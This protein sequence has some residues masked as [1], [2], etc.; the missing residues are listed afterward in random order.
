MPPE[1]TAAQIEQTKPYLEPIKFDSDVTPSKRHP[2]T[3]LLFMPTNYG[4]LTGV[5]LNDKVFCQDYSIRD[6]KDKPA[7]G[8]TTITTTIN[9][10]QIEVSDYQ[11][12]RIYNFNHQ[13]NQPQIERL[14]DGNVANGVY[15]ILDKGD[16]NTIYRVKDNIDKTNNGKEHEPRIEEDELKRSEVKVTDVGRISEIKRIGEYLMVT[17]FDKQDENRTRIVFIDQ[18]GKEVL[19][20]RVGY[21]VDKIVTNQKADRENKF[22]FVTSD[23]KVVIEEL[24]DKDGTLRFG[25]DNQFQAQNVGRAID[26]RNLIDVAILGDEIVL[27]VSGKSGKEVGKKM[28]SIV[29]GDGKFQLT[30]K[31]VEDVTGIT[32]LEGLPYRLHRQ[33]N[34]LNATLITG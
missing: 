18:N 7:G 9:N 20:Q 13:F 23:K 25:G 5:A 1:L 11:T 27:A 2:L 3:N 15:F 30:D 26:Y 32:Y 8:K 10:S 29:A 6:F 28:I 17:G 22:I 14:G 4:F 33:G 19:S 12:Q 31:E 34:N 21:R 24:T 16:K